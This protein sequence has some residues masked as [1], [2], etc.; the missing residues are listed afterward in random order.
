MAENKCK[1][2][3]CDSIFQSWC[4]LAR[5]R[6]DY[7]RIDNN[8]TEAYTAIKSLREDLRKMG[9][10]VNAHLQWANKERHKRE[11]ET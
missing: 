7:Q 4:P 6:K 10:L 1:C 8:L 5:L 9:D 2:A 11:G 3:E